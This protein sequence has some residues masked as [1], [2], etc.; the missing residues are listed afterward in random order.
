MTVN[1]PV[2]G[3]FY[4][5]SPAVEKFK[6]I[7]FGASTDAD[8]VI[9]ATGVYNMFYISQPCIVTGMRA[10]IDT[11]F[12]ATMT[13]TVG[14]SD[15]EDGYYTDT[16]LGPDDSDTEYLWEDAGGAYAKGRNY[17]AGGQYIHATI[18]TAA[19]DAGAG[20]LIISYIDIVS[21]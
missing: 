12:T 8:V 19:C 18:G 15:D 7:T 14:D 1:I 10:R 13:M 16:D 9:G 4:P 6:L 5:N 20:Q 11:A 3:D 17:V 2:E 21:T